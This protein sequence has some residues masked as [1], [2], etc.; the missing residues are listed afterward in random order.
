MKTK[1]E[2]LKVATHELLNT[3][4]GMADEARAVEAFDL[5][6]A[7]DLACMAV[8]AVRDAVNRDGKPDGRWAMIVELCG[9]HLK[10]R[11]SIG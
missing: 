5:A 3:F 1:E 8:L 9:K 6:D 4:K 7:A 10:S 2:V 11:L